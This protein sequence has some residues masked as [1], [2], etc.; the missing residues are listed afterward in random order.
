METNKSHQR[1]MCDEC[2]DS[3]SLL[4]EY[5]CFRVAQGIDSKRRKEK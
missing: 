4:E 2:R 3:Y 5:D 1:C